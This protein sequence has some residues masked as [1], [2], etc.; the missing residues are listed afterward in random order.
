MQFPFSIISFASIYWCSLPSDLRFGYKLINFE[1]TDLK[2]AARE[3][4]YT[5]YIDV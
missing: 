2:G 1:A 4:C 5:K 3:S